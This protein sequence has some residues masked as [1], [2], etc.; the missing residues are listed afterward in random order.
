M[1]LGKRHFTGTVKGYEEVLAAFCGLHFRKID[2]Q[3]ADGIVLEF[4]FRRA[5]PVL[6][7]RQATDAVA[8]EAT[9]QCRA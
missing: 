1:Q 9:V 3:I 6:A 2:V 8:L 4:L 7:Q 5:L